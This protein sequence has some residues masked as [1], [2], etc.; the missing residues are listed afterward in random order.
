[1]RRAPSTTSVECL[2]TQRSQTMRQTL[3]RFAVLSLLAGLLPPAC[4][5]AQQVGDTVMCVKDAQLK[6]GN[7]VVGTFGFAQVSTV[8]AI[9]GDWLWISSQGTPA[10]VQRR[11]VLPLDQAIAHF[12]QE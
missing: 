4:S 3:V 9:N 1:M 11:N 8:A 5:N 10:W 6:R 2:S 12:T 7:E